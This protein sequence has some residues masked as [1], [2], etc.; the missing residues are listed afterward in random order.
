MYCINVGNRVD[1]LLTKVEEN[2]IPNDTLMRKQSAQGA[3]WIPACLLQIVPNQVVT[4]TL[5]PV[6]TSQMIRH[7]LRLPAENVDLIE[8]EGL[9]IMGV[10]PDNEG[11]KPLVSGISYNDVERLIRIGKNEFRGRRRTN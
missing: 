7:A 6:H 4:T 2:T 8:D 9:E 5:G 11:Q 10:K 1:T 3:Q